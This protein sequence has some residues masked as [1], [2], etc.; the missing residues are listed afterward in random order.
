MELPLEQQA[1]HAKCFHPSGRFTEFPKKDVEQSIPARFEKL[2][3][4]M[5]TEPPSKWRIKP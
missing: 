5:A 2:P 3:R 1:I 4:D